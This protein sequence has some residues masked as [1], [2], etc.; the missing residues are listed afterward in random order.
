LTLRRPQDFVVVPEGLSAIAY[1][2][3]AGIAVVHGVLFVIRMAFRASLD[4]GIGP[5]AK[6]LLARDDLKVV[7]IHAIAVPAK[8]VEVEPVWDRTIQMLEDEPVGK[9]GMSVV[10]GGSEDAIAALVDVISPRPALGCIAARLAPELPHEVVPQRRARSQPPSFGIA[11]SPPT[12]VVALTPPSPI[13]GAV[14]VLDGAGH[15][16]SLHSMGAV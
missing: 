7:G 14:T 12:G 2:A 4:A 1:L 3:A 16:I 13:N 11:V 10:E 6:V 9:G 8:V 15:S 5:A